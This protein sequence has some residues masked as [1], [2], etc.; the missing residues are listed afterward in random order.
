MARCTLD[1]LVPSIRCN[2]IYLE[3]LAETYDR[4]QVTFDLSVYDVIDDEDGIADYLLADQYKKYINYVR[5][6]S[7]DTGFKKIYDLLKSRWNPDTQV[8]IHPSIQTLMMFSIIFFSGMASLRAGIGGAALIDKMRENPILKPSLMNASFTSQLAPLID[9]FLSSDYELAAQTGLP[10]KTYGKRYVNEDGQ[11]EYDLKIDPS[12]TRYENSNSVSEAYL[13]I[14]PMY[15]LVSRLNDMGEGDAFEN[16]YYD[17]ETVKFVFKDVHECAV[18]LEGLPANDTVQDFRAVERIAEIIEPFRITDYDELIDTISRSTGDSAATE[19]RVI[20]ELYTSYFGAPNNFATHNVFYYDKINFLINNGRYP[21]LYKNI[22]MPP[23]TSTMNPSTGAPEALTMIRDITRDIYER[24]VMYKMDIFRVRKDSTE[25]SK[26]IATKEQLVTGEELGFANGF[27]FVD[28]DF[29]EIDTG[30]YGYN[31]EI[32]AEDP[33]EGLVENLIVST[34]KLEKRIAQALWY[35]GVANVSDNNGIQPSYNELRDELSQA[36]K[37]Q[38]MMLNPEGAIRPLMDDFKKLFAI[39][40]GEYFD[41]VASGALTDLQRVLTNRRNLESLQTVL[42]DVLQE[43][44]KYYEVKETSHLSESSINASGIITYKKTWNKDVHP[45]KQE[46]MIINV[47]G[48]SS[49]NIPVAAYNSR[50]NLEAARMSVENPISNSN[51]GFVTPD[52]IDNVSVYETTAGAFLSKLLIDMTENTSNLDHTVTKYQ[53]LLG[54]DISQYTPAQLRNTYGLFESFGE[55]LGMTIKNKSALSTS[56]STAPISNTAPTS[57]GVADGVNVRSSLQLAGSGIYQPISV[58]AHEESLQAAEEREETIATELFREY[59]KKEDL[60]HRIIDSEAGYSLFDRNSIIQGTRAS[61][62]LSVDESVEA[63]D[64]ESATRNIPSLFDSKLENILNKST[65]MNNLGT[66]AVSRLILDNTFM[67]Y[68][69]AGFNM[70]MEPFWRHLT[71]IS[72]IQD[73]LAGGR[74]KVL[75]KLKRYKSSE[76]NIGQGALSD[77]DIFLEYFYLT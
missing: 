53:E 2:T 25:T 72:R 32:E 62:K 42:L 59:Q 46:Q 21:W 77:R 44:S 36:A 51:L 20:S 47:V 22:F 52:K 73:L 43:V 60:L 41:S 26:R 38:I 34:K 68:Y 69:L 31:I 50:M 75:C 3:P 17:E 15:D 8:G 66:K 13:H 11:I 1:D 28:I 67:V 61:M 58:E 37:L 14:I 40:T 39:F 19:R 5:I 23:A 57:F 27:G 63:F 35:I 9:N 71:D 55:K 4:Y 29:S 54:G 48:N 74:T 10:S 70:N 30:V 33:M 64:T 18:I 65:Q 45:K 76:S 56:P 16:F 49:V 12:V 7:R 24:F 6:Y